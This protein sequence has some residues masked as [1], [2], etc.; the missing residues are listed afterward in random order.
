[1]LL[2]LRHVVLLFCVYTL[3]ASLSEVQRL[4]G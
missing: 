1:M 4:L 2:A 3:V